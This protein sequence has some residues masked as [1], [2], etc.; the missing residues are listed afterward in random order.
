MY[1]LLL[2]LAVAI[3]CLPVAQIA[4]ARDVYKWSGNDGS[5]YYG[6]QPPSGNMASLE[7]LQ[8]NGAPPPVQSP[9][10]AD[11][12]AVAYQQALE[13]AGRLQADRL[14]REQAH[15]EREALRLRKRETRLREQQQWRDANPSVSYYIPYYRK[16][17]PH[18]YPPRYRRG[19]PGMEGRW[20][21][22]VQGR[23]YSPFPGSRQHIPDRLLSRTQ[24]AQRLQDQV[25]EPGLRKRYRPD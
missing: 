20:Q 13:M 8:V 4:S 23:G 2:L 17:S 21:P 7:V 22:P 14:A 18:R 19:T 11:S 3:G 25:P 10:D 5:T 24:Q 6:E 12:A 16:P 9:V 1:G 15:L